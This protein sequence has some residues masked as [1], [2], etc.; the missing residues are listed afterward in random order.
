M[1]CSTLSGQMA[2]KHPKLGILVREDGFVFHRST[3]NRRGTPVWTKGTLHTRKKSVRK[4]YKVFINGKTTY[5]VHRLVAECFIPNPEGKPTVDHI[6]RD[7]TDNRVSNLRW[8]TYREQVENSS[9]VLDRADYGIRECE[10]TVEYH[11]QWYRKR[12]KHIRDKE[13]HRE[14][15]RLYYKKRRDEINAK[16]TP[17]V[18]SQA[19]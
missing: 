14:S 1:I 7:S 5:L 11:K 12:G 3:G 17:G 2:I 16:K 19:S 15:N 13:K 8:A 9:R 6:N 4:T 10:D 18:C